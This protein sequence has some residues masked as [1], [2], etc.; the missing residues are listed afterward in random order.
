MS[1]RRR[2]RTQV[3]VIGAGPAGLVL[4]NVLRRAG[5][6]THVVERCSQDAVERRAR[7]GLLE[8]R[9]VAY[10]DSHGLADRL[11]A[12]GARHGSCDFLCQGR[13]LR[14]DY[15]ALTGGAHHWVYPQQFLARDL[16]ASLAQTSQPPFFGQPVTDISLRGATARVTCPAAT[17]DCD[18]VVGCDGHQGI[19]RTTVPA[20]SRREITRS[21][22]YDWLT[23]L[24]EVDRP[25]ERVVYGVHPRGFAGMMPRTQNLA[26]LYLQVPAGETP[27]NWPTARVRAEL[28][29]RLDSPKAHLPRVLHVSDA[30]A[31]RIRSTLSQ[32]FRHGRLFLAGDA[33]HVLTPA[34][35]KGMNLAIGDA[36]DLAFSLIRRYHDGD[37]DG[38]AAYSTR[39]LKQARHAQEF[40]DHLLCLLHL[41]ESHSA[42][43]E[44]A[45][46]SAYLRG[47][48]EPNPK[49]TAFAH[50]YVGSG[51]AL[52]GL[53]PRL[54]HFP[55]PRGTSVC[56]S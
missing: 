19:T 44:L 52:A 33:A 34:G 43:P 4:S 2:L 31:L 30:G 5:I 40:S 1:A 35:A 11:I 12:D 49:A 26:R 13:R 41:P 48:T 10:L 23:L 16:I 56:P 25:V 18:Y 22:P 27:D 51:D 8:H 36:A 29:A 28:F 7:A 53:L 20:H 15:C 17:I 38:L 3:A 55:T 47:L 50:Q 21:C 37:P 32:Q 42:A 54:P 46:R 45:W 6:D 9:T 24:A 39:R 14:L